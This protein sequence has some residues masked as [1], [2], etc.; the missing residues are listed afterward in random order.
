MKGFVQVV[1][2]VKSVQVVKIVQVV[3]TVKGQGALNQESKYR[4][5][6]G[7]RLRA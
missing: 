6:Q 5:A 1:E 4:E 2:I 3:E 7:L